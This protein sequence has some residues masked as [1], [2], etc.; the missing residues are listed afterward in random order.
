M[1]TM[2]KKMLNFESDNKQIMIMIMIIKISL[3]LVSMYMLLFQCVL[4]AA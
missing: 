1:P 4:R 2:V 3:S